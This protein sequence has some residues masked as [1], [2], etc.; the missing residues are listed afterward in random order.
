[1]SKWKAEA[2][3]GLLEVFRQGKGGGVSDSE[4]L[5]ERLWRSPKYESVYLE[6][7]TG[8]RHARRVI[9]SWL[10]DYNH[11]RPHLAL[12]GRTPAEAYAAGVKTAGLEAAA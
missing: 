8:G 7:R 3:D 4:R 9:A 12:A 6:E 1:M 5:I 2:H 10:D 11:R